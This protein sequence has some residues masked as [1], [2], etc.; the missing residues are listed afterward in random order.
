MKEANRLDNL[1]IHLG[2]AK[3]E[4]SLL[5]HGWCKALKQRRNLE[6]ATE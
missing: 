1:Y 6:L 5:Q 2:S 3:Q 4:A